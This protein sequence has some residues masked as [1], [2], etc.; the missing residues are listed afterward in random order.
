MS[1]TNFAKY[2]LL[3]VV[4]IIVA[5]MNT[6]TNLLH[7]FTAFLLTLF[8]FSFV[9][10][11]NN[12][13]GLYLRLESPEEIFS[14]TPCQLRY[15]ISNQTGYPKFGL[16][17]RDI[18]VQYSFSLLELPA[19]AS[20]GVY[21]ETKFARRGSY[22]WQHLEL[23]SGFP[24]NFVQLRKKIPLRHN[25]LVLPKPLSV[26]LA[27]LPH[28]ASMF[29]EGCFI[30]AITRTASQDFSGLRDYQYGDSAK[31][32]HWKTSAKLQKL[33]TKEYEEDLPAG[34]SVLLDIFPEDYG[35]ETRAALFESA[36]TLTASLVWEITAKGYLILFACG[37]EL[38][39]YGR[40]KPHALNIL[41]LL[42]TADVDKIQDLREA[43]PVALN[44]IP[45]G[46]T[47]IVI[48]FKPRE[49][50]AAYVTKLA[51]YCQV[52]AIVVDS[53][54]PATEVTA[55]PYYALQKITDASVVLSSPDM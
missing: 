38:I 52:I 47:V 1:L 10:V 19:K 30:S 14:Q 39:G 51:R 37:R 46:T 53:T 54:A 33:I 40:G 7:L 24:F 36:I 6:A 26:S 5:A 34:I 11:R 4:A 48:F 2:Y 28:K 22:T 3:L 50:I 27:P 32:I 25:F 42:A 43:V 23:H 41:R 18:L 21:Y 16:Q 8:I 45:A 20:L 12:L 49:E 55:A 44:Q 35:A 31:S 17:F 29:R 15:L 9:L 13:R